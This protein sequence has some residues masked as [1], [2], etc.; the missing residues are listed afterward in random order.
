MPT[1]VYRVMTLLCAVVA[2]LPIGTNLGLL[3]LL[4]MLV[5]GCLLVSRGAVI[6]GLSLL[7]LPA[8]VV[9]RAWAALGRGHWTSGRLLA[10]WATVVRAEGFW[11]AH[12]YAGYRPVSADVTGYWR[13]R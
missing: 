7:G 1:P 10:T 5:S 2:P 13:P 4:W 12:V 11:Q 8:A 3:Y 9:W 6:P